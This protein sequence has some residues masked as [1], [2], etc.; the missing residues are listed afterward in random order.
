MAFLIP[1]VT[2]RPTSSNVTTSPHED[3]S[4]DTED[5]PQNSSPSAAIQAPHNASPQEA[6]HD[7]E[8]C[9]DRST[10]KAILPISRKPSHTNERRRNTADKMDMRFLDELKR[11]KEQASSQNDN[12]L[13]RYFLLNLL[14]MMKQLSPPDNMDIKIEI[15]KAF[16]RKLFK[17]IPAVQ[18]GYWLQE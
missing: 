13:D 11:L 9:E 8:I 5:T 15:Y 12:D 16:R 6:V 2:P 1:H 4:H 3:S 7:I 10:D 18:C 14:P 17:L